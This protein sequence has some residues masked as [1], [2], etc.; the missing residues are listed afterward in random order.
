M[1]QLTLTTTV[2][3]DAIQ[4]NTTQ[5]LYLMASLKAPLMESKEQERAP[6][7]IVCVID[8][9][10]SMSGDKIGLVRA[11]LQFLVEQLKPN[12]RLSI[13]TFASNVTTQLPFVDMATGRSRAQN[14]VSQLRASGGTFLS[15]GLFAGFDELDARTTP[16]EVSSLLIFTDGQA[17]NGIKNPTELATQ[18]EKRIQQAGRAIST[19][20]FGFG[21]DHDATLM[22]SIAEAGNG[23][24][25]YLENN[26][27]IAGSFGDCLGGLLSVAAQN[28]KLRIEPCSGVTLKTIHSAYKKVTDTAQCVELSIGDL[29]SEEQKDIVLE[30]VVGATQAESQSQQ[31]V[32]FTLMYF[33]VIESESVEVESHA[34]VARPSNKPENVVVNFE[35]DK[36]RNRVDTAA[37]LKESRELAD[38]GEL[39]KA[40]D[41]LQKL[42]SR[43]EKSPSANDPL[44]QNLQ[45]DIKE[46]MSGMADR[47]TYTSMG[48]KVVNQRWASHNMQ[49]CNAQE[50]SPYITNKKMLMKS[51][52]M[53]SVQAPQQQQAPQREQLQ[54]PPQQ[55]RFG[56]LFRKQSK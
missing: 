12:D 43:I 8:T 25:Y 9:S 18:I 51:S 13:V 31:V 49:R 36:Q 53:S 27:T 26:D 22:R 2:E 38:S 10:G 39:E 28:I 52:A 45:N 5:D 29:Y 6:I 44:V 3:F 42:Q 24:Y 23:M 33:N 16:S 56:G 14:V 7:D 15:G 46:V 40:K 21:R 55:S 47:Q 11:S 1:S 54:S 34:T 37:I 17:T 19:F 35:L 50:A 41:A 48:S 32:K 30:V 4:H 20:S